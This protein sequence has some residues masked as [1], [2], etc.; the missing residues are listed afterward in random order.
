MRSVSA[1]CRKNY[2]YIFL[3]IL[4]GLFLVLFRS[5]YLMNVDDRVYSTIANAPLAE[6]VRFMRYHY[7]YCNGRT[8]VHL[9]LLALLRFGVWPWRVLMPLLLGA[10]CILAARL[11]APS[12]DALQ[13]TLAMTC[14]S[15]LSVSATLYADTLFWET[16]SV[17][18]IL[19]IVFVL[20]LF[21]MLQTGKCLWLAPLVGLLCGASTE[22]YGMIT[23]GGLLLYYCCLA[24]RKK[25]FSR[26]IAALTV[27]CTLAGLLTV[28]L[29]PS[30][31][32]RT[33]AETSGL[34]DKFSM[35]TFGLW[36]H[37]PETLTLLCFLA[38]AFCLYLYG[39]CALRMQ[40]IILALYA[41]ALAGSFAISFLHIPL[42]STLAVYASMLLFLAGAFAAAILALRLEQNCIPLIGLLL[43]GGAQV[44]MLVT[45][46]IAVRTM[47]PSIFC[48]LVFAVALLSR[49]G[50]VQKIPRAAVCAGCVLVAA[51]AVW[52][53]YGYVRTAQNQTA[54]FHAGTRAENHI[55]APQTSADVDRIIDE[56]EDV[57]LEEIRRHAQQSDASCD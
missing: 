17:N 56:I 2:G 27:L 23:F 37:S 30:V 5:F 33:Y 54:E 57:R 29:S 36:F 26:V 8:W 1:F 6:I 22:Q 4:V 41:A 9:V 40:R 52:N 3:A 42:L 46:R 16:G 15:V 32:A 25:Q 12:T 7:G 43:G 14:A 39:C 34:F 18:Y 50:K 47:T 49:C 20:L 51:I 35:L 38:L 24:L 11:T 31:R 44:M 28:V 19:P 45:Q 53:V 48:F 55:H 21:R 13:K 10:I